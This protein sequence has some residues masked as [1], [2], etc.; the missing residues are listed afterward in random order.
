MR[1]H[2]QGRVELGLSQPAVSGVIADL[3]HT[4]GVPLFDRSHAGV[5]PTPY[6]QALLRRGLA[7]FDE[8]K[9]GLRDIE[10]LADPARGEVR[11]GCPDS[12]A[13]AILAPLARDLC[14]DFPGIALTI[15][16]VPKPTL[17]VPE[18]RAREL[19]LLLARLSRPRGD[20]PL[21]GDLNVEILFDDE[22]VVA[23]GANSRWARR[24]KLTLA[25]LH[26]ASW[27]GA[28]RAD[29][30]RHA[31]RAGVPRQ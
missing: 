20:D 1:Q 30:H 11:V 18:L 29:P 7:A 14:R 9:L 31:D 25:D 24:R 16:S 26:D 3:E 12:I 19:D 10:F 27:I 21:S 13:G 23:A 2:G 8:L 17:D 5:E 6:G 28:S 4:F 22:V 15:A